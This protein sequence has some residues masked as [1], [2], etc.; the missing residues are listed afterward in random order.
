MK[1]IFKNSGLLSCFIALL[2]TSC[3]SFLTETPESTYTTETFFTKESDFKYAINGV[4]AALQQVYDGT[5]ATN[6]NYGLLR[7]LVVRSD[8]HNSFG[9]NLYDNGAGT[10]SDNATVTSTD[11]AWKECYVI[12]TRCNSILIRIDKVEFS[13]SNYKNYIKGEAYAMRGWAYMTLGQLFGGIPLIV[14]AEYTSEQTKEIGRSTQEETFAQAE[15]DLMNA[16]EL[17]PTTWS[18]ESIGRVTKYAAQ[19]VLGRLYM[20]L[21]NYNKASSALKSVIS[22]GMYE[23]ANKYVDCFSEAAKN[24]K[25]RVWEVQYMGGSVGEGEYYSEISIPEYY[26]GPWAVT[27]SSA[28]MR[29]STN[30]L[31]E[32][33]NGDL[34]KKITTADN[35]LI[36]N[37]VDE[38]TWFIKFNHY[39]NKPSTTNNWAINLPIIRYTDVCMLYAEAQNE[40]NNGPT[41]EAI[42]IL[43]Q[44]RA[45][46]G[47]G[48]LNSAQI[49]SKSAFLS[50]IKHE[51]RIEFAYEGLRWF[52]LVRW[53]D[54][55]NV[56]STF[57]KDAD[58][59]N[60]LFSNNVKEFRKIFA[61]P[62]EEINRYANTSKMWQ[63]PEY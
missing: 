25:E 29:V 53:G 20:F 15:S 4:Y 55:V 19:A 32:Y 36:Q 38:Y 1:K 54:F 44:V 39:I 59:G 28:A 61:I 31:N 18:T 33:E 56:M 22:S 30:L 48:V 11:K 37:N 57:F 26:S 60:G 3:D 63:N 8:D 46:A 43:N 10:F 12:I 42:N 40:I 58:E 51:R 6:A 62:L 27:G 13:D 47:L 2:F 50:V 5:D 49:S 17:L 7:L 41:T 21:G 34:R 14:D 24:G 35:L 23:M 16:S 52:D 9:T 45:R